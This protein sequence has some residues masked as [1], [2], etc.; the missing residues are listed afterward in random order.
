MNPQ[1]DLSQYEVQPLV[2]DAQNYEVKVPEESTLGSIAR[3]A[4]RVGSRIGESLIGLPQDLRQIAGG[5]IIKGA[6]KVTGEEQPFLREQLE[7]AKRSPSSADIREKASEFTGGYTEPKTPGEDKADEFFT[8]L[9]MLALP[10]KGKIPFARALGI[11]LLG[12]GAKIASEKFGAT[13]TSQDLTKLGTFFTVGLLSAPGN[14]NKFVSNLYNKR[15]AS[16]PVGADVD[17][18]VLNRSL[19]S[20]KTDLEKGVPGTAENAV[21]KYVDTLIDKTAGGRIAVDELTAVKPQINTKIGELVKEGTKRKDARQKFK[22]LGKEIENTIEA[23]GKTNPKFLELHKNANQAYAAI[24]E[25][26]RVSQFIRDKVPDVKKLV[27]GAALETLLLGPLAT[28]RTIGIGL[29]GV[30]SIKAAELAVRINKSPV[31]RKYYIA[32]IK[33]AIKENVGVVTQNLKALDHSMQKEDPELYNILKN[34]KSSS[35]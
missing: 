23:Y 26:K 7:K 21:L 31:L 27:T 16:L 25:S 20:L 34:Q 28:A 15:N 14:A 18:T 5:L 10:V 17:A 2:D 1:E 32:A 13:E 4:T 19:K 35:E 9:A 8:D 11:D 24:E 12:H 33:G 22:E 3:G 6:E 30:G 29:A